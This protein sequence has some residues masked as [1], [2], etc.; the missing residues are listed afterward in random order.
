MQIDLLTWIPLMVWGILLV[1]LLA[2][3]KL[4]IYTVIFGMIIGS[5]I[6]IWAAPYNEFIILPIRN[7]LLFGTALNLRTLAAYIHLTSL[8]FSGAVVMWN[9]AIYNEWI[10]GGP[11]NKSLRESTG[12]QVSPLLLFLGL[13]GLFAFTYGVWDATRESATGTSP[14]LSILG[15][16][17]TSFSVLGT[18]ILVGIIIA[19]IVAIFL[20]I[21]VL[22]ANR[23]V[24]A[25]SK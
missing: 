22:R 5:V 20:I 8:I 16:G 23:N 25:A 2:G 24:G 7:H 4:N 3:Q 15:F 13:P 11:D 18:T 1:S 17:G 9:I 10:R 12:G 21:L 19:A 6:T 14:L